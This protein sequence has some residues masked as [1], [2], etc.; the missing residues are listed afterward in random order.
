MFKFA[1][2]SH[3]WGENEP[4][5]SDILHKRLTE[6]HTVGYKKLLKF[7]QRAT[8]YDCCYAWSDTCCINKDSSVELD[9]AIRSMYRWYSIAAVCIVHLAQSLT[10]DDFESEPWFKRGWTLQELL[11]PQ[12]IKF[13]GTDWEPIYR[14]TNASEK[15]GDKAIKEIW[16]A[17]EKVTGI[18]HAD[19]WHFVP[20]CDR[21]AEKMAWAS[22]RKTTKI[23]DTAYCLLGLF[24]VSLPIAYG[25]ADRAWYRLMTIIANECTDT[26]FFAWAG[27][28][29]PYS[30]TF[31]CSPASYLKLDSR[32]SASLFNRRHPSYEVTKL[33][34]V[35]KLVMTSALCNV[36]EDGDGRDIGYTVTPHR[37]ESFL[38]GADVLPG[39]RKDYVLGIVNFRAIGDTA[40]VHVEDICHCLILARERSGDQG[41]IMV[42]TECVVVV[43]C[44]EEISKSPE[45]VLLCHTSGYDGALLRRAHRYN[46]V[47]KAID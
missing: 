38:I 28:P 15:A 5:F 45:T 3:R 14:E 20:S 26:S 39:Q 33:G 8:D 18:L 37:L 2:F 17:I 35:I 19:L 7:C 27:Q 30:R 25:E 29:S 47:V 21:V 36:L 6:N 31:P 1:I 46:P 40:V 34:V 13:Y 11:A 23:E 32:T 42:N 41:W 44:V 43:R 22:Q 16:S 4:Q 9:E 10:V 24:N 12:V